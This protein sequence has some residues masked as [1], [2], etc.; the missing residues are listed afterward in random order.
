MASEEPRRRAPGMSPAQRREMI[1]SVA[2]PLVAE[3]GA[4]VTT[5]LV[6]KVAGIG[7]A[8][9]FRAFKDK[10]ELLDAVRAEA[11]R[12]DHAVREIES[13]P[14]DQP[15]ADRLAEAADALGAHLARMA[16]ILSALH[17]SGQDPTRQA[18]RSRVL[19]DGREA[20]A[21]DS[22]IGRIRDAIADLF[23][24]EEGELRLPRRQ[25]AGMFLGLLFSRARPG[26]GDVITTA[27]LVDVF[28]YGAV[29]RSAG[30]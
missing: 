24:P 19:P 8:T 12:H 17:A 9:I 2:L 21:R 14:M 22:S 7:E 28:L 16:T 18:L 26:A 30:E 4:K 27:E 29:S 10:D 13:I 11:L 5:S 23:E 1:V 6:A 15:L 20:A 3:H 25:A